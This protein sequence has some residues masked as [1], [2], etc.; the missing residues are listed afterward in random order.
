MPRK[1]PV[2]ANLYA[3]LPAANAWN[4]GTPGSAATFLKSA[5]VA[6]RRAGSQA[7]FPASGAGAVELLDEVAPRDTLLV[8]L[9]PD[10]MVA[11]LRVHPGLR[12]VPVTQL[13]PLW[14][15]SEALLAPLS[16]A[17]G[18]ARIDFAVTVLSQ[19][20]GRPLAGVQVN[21]FTD[22]RARRGVPGVTDQAGIATLSVPAGVAHFEVIEAYTGAG[23][24][25]AYARDVA[26]GPAGLSLRAA[27]I[28]MST[29]GVAAHFGLQGGDADGAGVVVGVI[30]T[31]V[32]RHRD[33][34]VAREM[35]VVRGEDPS[36]VSDFLGHGTHVAGIIAGRGVPGQGMRGVAPGVTLHV[37]KVF[38]KR[39]ERAESFSIA[40]AIRQAV[41]DG[42]D[43]INLSL[44][45]EADMPEVLREILRAR[46]LGV[47]CL[48]AS[49]NDDRAAVSYPARYSAVL[50]VAAC[51]RR[52]TYPAGALQELAEVAPFG[53]D[54]DNYVAGFSNV[55]P[56][57]GLTAP[58][59]G[60]V[61]TYGRQYA[62]QDGTS[63]ACPLAAGALAR[64]VAGNRRL[65][66]MVRDQKR[67]DA[68]VKLALSTALPLG[69]GARFEG[70]GILR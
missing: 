32:S 42:C 70:S 36:D 6:L 50:A 23:H 18:A 9:D 19:A 38:G 52:N 4:T 28:D 41:D 37:Y 1:K 20:D 15:R 63:M 55:G 3:L 61:S 43:L 57:I 21:A 10:Q 22:R 39:Q 16:I 49:G 67:S 30:D 64:A 56:E 48:A 27:P 44:G 8:A 58:G 17:G 33:L 34:V 62:V 29:A 47:V 14:L 45:G 40:K 59:V 51:G 24:W 66:R 26:V 2:A 46:A 7:S 31:G 69:F 13:A 54:K 65:L 11:L 35:N 25:P 53:V 68:I 5:S 60:I 12:I